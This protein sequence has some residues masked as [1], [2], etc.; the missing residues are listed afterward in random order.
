MYKLCSSRVSAII[1]IDLAS[2]HDS[3]AWEGP[4]RQSSLRIFYR[5]GT[6]C[7]AGGGGGKNST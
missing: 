4:V 3:V 5:Y 6:S 1:M 7:L 2:Q